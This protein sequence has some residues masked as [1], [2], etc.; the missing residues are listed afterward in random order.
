[1]SM[2]LR[3]HFGLNVTQRGPDVT[4]QGDI[5]TTWSWCHA[6][7]WHQDRHVTMGPLH[8]TK[9]PVFGIWCTSLVV[10]SRYQVLMSLDQSNGDEKWWGGSQCELHNS[11]FWKASPDIVIVLQRWHS[12]PSIGN[13]SERLACLL[14][15]K[16]IG[17]WRETYENYA[18][19]H[20]L[21]PIS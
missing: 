12:A 17:T 6:S 10:M 9:G 14:M 8:V 11:S 2:V 5:R 20:D 18:I 3:W 15:M 13:I 16:S 7:M 1:M 21:L 19:F 4:C